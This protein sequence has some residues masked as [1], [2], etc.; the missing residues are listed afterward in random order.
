MDTLFLLQ[1]VIFSFIGL[2]FPNSPTET[3]HHILLHIY[4]HLS[5]VWSPKEIIFPMF[6]FWG[7]THILPKLSRKRTVVVV[8]VDTVIKALL[9]NNTF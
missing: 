5:F 7:H 8:Y 3:I 9:W 2:D 4:K 6:A 1:W